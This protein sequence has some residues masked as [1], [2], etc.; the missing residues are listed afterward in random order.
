[1][2]RYTATTSSPGLEINSTLCI[3]SGALKAGDII[4]IRHDEDVAVP[5]RIESMG[6]SG[7]VVSQAGRT[8][9]FRPWRLGDACVD[10]FGGAISCWTV[11][12]VEDDSLAEAS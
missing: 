7:L 3:R 10:R 8:L 4:D 11:E 2:N 6:L 5:A 9:S 12:R 1:M